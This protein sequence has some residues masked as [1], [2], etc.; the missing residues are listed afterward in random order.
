M[1]NRSKWLLAGI[2]L[3]GLLVLNRGEL[4]NTTV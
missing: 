4:F 2:V 3:V 1:R